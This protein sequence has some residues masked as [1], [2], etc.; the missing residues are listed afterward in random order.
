M[1]GQAVQPWNQKG[2]GMWRL[3]GRNI[4]KSKANWKKWKQ[5]TAD[6][7]FSAQDDLGEMI[8]KMEHEDKDVA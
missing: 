2:I 4:Q 1:I 3:R 8:Q 5:M 6:A 7:K